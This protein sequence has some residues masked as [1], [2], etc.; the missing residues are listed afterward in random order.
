MEIRALIF[1]FNGVLVDDE[2][3]HF[4]AFQNTI[5]AEGLD[6][7]WEATVKGTFPTKTTTSLP[8]FWRIR[9]ETVH[10]RSSSGSSR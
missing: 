8:T 4:Q 3:I 2:S 9:I 5:R 6:L 10:P 7:D 1:D